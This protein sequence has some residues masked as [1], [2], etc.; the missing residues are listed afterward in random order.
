MQFHFWE[1]TN[2]NQTFILD[3]HRQFICSVATSETGPP[4]Q[5]LTLFQ[6]SCPVGE[7]GISRE[8]QIPKKKNCP[9]RS[10]DSNCS[11]FL[12][13]NNSSLLFLIPVLSHIFLYSFL[14]QFRCSSYL[15]KGVPLTYPETE[16]LDVIETKV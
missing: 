7:R 9:E 11:L 13:R 6:A 12:L 4:R 2:R 16:F 8:N 14:F 5:N 10:F 1:Y 3:S 15:K